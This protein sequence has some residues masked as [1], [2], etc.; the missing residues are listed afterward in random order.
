MAT[1]YGLDDREVGIR[2]PV[3][4]RMSSISSRR[5]LGPTQPPI[6]WVSDDLSLGVNRPGREAH[7]SPQFGAGVKK[8]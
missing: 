3:G 6:Q 1:G 5:A 7:Y 4:S 8:T 2:A